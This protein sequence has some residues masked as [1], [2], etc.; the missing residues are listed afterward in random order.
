ME[1][2]NKSKKFMLFGLIA[3]VITIA[4]SSTYA[5]YV[6]STS[7][8]EVT[9]I[10]A[11]VGS[12]TVTFDGGS[13]INASLRPVSDKS[14]GIVKEIKVK[15]DT[16]GLTFNMYL[17][18][19]SIATELKDVSFR[20]EFYK[21]TTK[22]KEGNFSDT[23]LNSNTTDCST[24]STKHITL[25][26]GE[27]I[28]TSNTIYTLYI[29][30]DGV[31]Y[32]NPST[33]M[34]KE[35]N[36]KL[37]ADGE[38]AVLAPLPADVTLSRLNALN[39]TIKVD[40][41]H[42]PDF[43]TVSGNSGIK[44]DNN[45]NAVIAQNLGDGTNGIYVAEDDLGKS[46]YFRGDVDNNY[47]KFGT[48]SQ[49]LYYGKDSNSKYVTGT[50]C[51][52]IPTE[53]KKLAST[54]DSMYWRIIRIN[55]DGSVRMIY[56][57]TEAYANGSTE[58]PTSHIGYSAYNTN[59]NDNAYVGYMY[60]TAGSSTYEETHKNTNN[61]TIK[62]FIDNWYKTNLSNYAS[63][64]QDAIYCND[65]TIIPV[66][67]FLEYTPT[68]NGT[69]TLE[70]AYSDLTRNTI[71]NPRTPSLKC[72]NVNDRFTVS[73]ENGNGALT[74]PIGLITTDETVLS[75]GGIVDFSDA[76]NIKFVSNPTFYLYTGDYWFWTMTPMAFMDGFA[77][78]DSVVDGFVSPGFAVDSDGGGVRVVVSL[79]SDA[80]TG[81]DGTMNNPFIVG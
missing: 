58:Q 15:A 56:A 74:Y 78:V 26:T 35:F 71:N 38:G 43:S 59:Y 45:D 14:K 79:K 41:E 29:W 62:T 3:L 11:G 1:E 69:G 17:D 37:H 10:V 30:I 80:I 7:D 42:T 77:F 16:T 63:Y 65:R 13:D 24:N 44:Y 49:D 67:S 34:G 5:Y 48:Y 36:F 75:G 20:Y 32:V 54:G 23:Y 52:S 2:N 33:M 68:G 22:V 39:S 76:D 27:S 6:W 31:N 46:Y 40:T 55:G 53:C 28:S 8:N 18:I 81:G 70:T 12:A 64:L 60:G 72:T 50:S 47:V 9:K 51:D 73:T 25:L 66:A 61:S 57:G 19:T 4:V 21:G